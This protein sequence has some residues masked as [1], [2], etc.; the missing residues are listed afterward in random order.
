MTAK[1]D[2]MLALAML[3][4]NPTFVEE[5]VIRGRVREIKQPYKAPKPDR[6][7]LTHVPNRDGVPVAAMSDD[8]PTEERKAKGP[9][10]REATNVEKEVRHPY[11]VLTTMERMRDDGLI[12]DEECKAGHTFRD[13]FER[14]GLDPLRAAK[15]E[16]SSHSTAETVTNAVL[17]AR[18]AVAADMA[19]LGGW[20]TPVAQACWWVVGADYSIN[21]FAQRFSWGSGR[22]LDRKTA[23]GLV[24]AALNV[25][26]APK[27]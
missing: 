26:A 5:C 23:Q 3:D 27:R 6:D 10:I 4:N 9:M 22:S 8:G 1:N 2:P 25:L 18:D 14:G 7:P 15:L 16:C 24:I 19:L 12:S 21:Q 20:G 17:D 11:R 13:N